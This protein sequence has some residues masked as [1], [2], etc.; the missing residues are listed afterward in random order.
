MNL[1]K[2]NMNIVSYKQQFDLNFKELFFLVVILIAIFF[3]Q[4]KKF[5]SHFKS[6]LLVQNWKK[7]MPTFILKNIMNCVWIV[8][9]SLIFQSYFFV[10]NWNTNEKLLIFVFIFF[11]SILCQ[12]KKKKEINVQLTFH[13][14]RINYFLLLS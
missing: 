4:K 10:Q 13:I 1:L 7:R 6:K 5:S 14:M 9:Y 11:N 12:P 8:F 3:H 2:K